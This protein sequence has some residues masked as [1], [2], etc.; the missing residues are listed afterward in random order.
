MAA[1]FF[2]ILLFVLS[3]SAQGNRAK[4]ATTGRVTGEADTITDPEITALD[5]LPK[6]YNQKKC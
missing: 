2:Y 4:D 1:V 3:G 6:P 5:A